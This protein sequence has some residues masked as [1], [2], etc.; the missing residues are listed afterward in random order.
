MRDADLVPAVEVIRAGNWVDRRESLAFFLTHPRSYP[1]VAE[2]NGAI[3]GTSVATQNGTVGW[4]GL[5][6]VTPALR[7]RGPRR[8]RPRSPGL[9]TTRFKPDGEYVLF[10]GP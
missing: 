10:K 1:F 5:V 3:V 8:D 9:R 7:G 4:V 2:S 6:F